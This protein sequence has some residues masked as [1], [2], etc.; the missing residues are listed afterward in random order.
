MLSFSGLKEPQ[1][2]Q[3]WATSLLDFISKMVSSVASLVTL[4]SRRGRCR[5]GPRISSCSFLSL[6]LT[7]SPFVSLSLS[8]FL[9]PY[10][11]CSASQVPFQ[12]LRTR[13]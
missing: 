11:T 13:Q 4:C 6:S 7:F 12:V 2:V 5:E 3:A 8:L 10:E 9:T 1:R